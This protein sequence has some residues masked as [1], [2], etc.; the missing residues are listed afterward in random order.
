MENVE[1]IE[2]K[3]GKYRLTNICY[4]ETFTGPND[5]TYNYRPVQDGLALEKEIDEE[6]HYFVIAFIKWDETST[7]LEE[8]SNRFYTE[9][10]NGREYNNV[11][12]L[13]GKA[14][15]LINNYYYPERLVEEQ[16]EEVEEEHHLEEGVC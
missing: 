4:L 13:W 3:K 11:R 9:V 6:G 7:Q 5:I 1:K 14:V 12:E 15:E 10:T 8:V 16:V 2:I